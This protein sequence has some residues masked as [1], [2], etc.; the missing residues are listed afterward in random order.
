MEQAKLKAPE[1]ATSCT[2]EGALY[3]VKYG[4]IKVAPEH[5]ALL[6]PHGYAMADQ[7]Q[8]EKEGNG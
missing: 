6:I 5:V 1:G 7:M 2:V 4:R 8:D 3:V